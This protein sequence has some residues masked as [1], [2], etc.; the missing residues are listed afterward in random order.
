M[1]RLYCI[2]LSILMVAIIAN[3]IAG[4][5][6]LKS[7]YDLFELLNKYGFEAFSKLKVLDW[8]WLFLVYPLILGFS[9]LIGEKIYNIIY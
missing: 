2:G 1:I 9:Y 6:G 7:W 3:G 8:I 5:I 4:K